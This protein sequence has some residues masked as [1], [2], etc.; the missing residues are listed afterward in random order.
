MDAY[1]H[2]HTHTHAHTHLGNYGS[3][4]TCRY[5]KKTTTPRHNLTNQCVAF[6]GLIEYENW[7]HV[8]TQRYGDKLC[9]IVFHDSLYS[10]VRHYFIFLWLSWLEILALLSAKCNFGEIVLGPLILVPGGGA[11]VINSTGSVKPTAAVYRNRQ[12]RLFPGTVL[13]HSFNMFRTECLGM[14]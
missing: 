10:V 12:S 13:I 1:T 11:G 6:L 9:A 3:L 8:S 14:S 7:L 2:N 4:K 5:W